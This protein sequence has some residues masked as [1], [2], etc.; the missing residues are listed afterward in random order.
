MRYITLNRFATSL[1]LSSVERIP[2]FLG[3]DNK[4]II[5]KLGVLKTMND[6]HKHVA[7]SKGIKILIWRSL[8]Y[9]KVQFL[10]SLGTFLP[11]ILYGKNRKLDLCYL[12]GGFYFLEPFGVSCAYHLENK[13]FFIGYVV[14]FSMG[15]ESGMVFRI[16]TYSQYSLRGWVVICLLI[17]FI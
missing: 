5:L 3:P 12:I 9:L 10:F 14:S 17:L 2:L 11:I 16:D 4:F 15:R 8:I 13:V 6:A 7:K 1:R